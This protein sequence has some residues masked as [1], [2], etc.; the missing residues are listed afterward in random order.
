MTQVRPQQRACLFAYRGELCLPKTPQV[1]WQTAHQGLARSLSPTL[2][3]CGRSF[4]FVTKQKAETLNL[5]EWRFTWLRYE[6]MCVGPFALGIMGCIQRILGTGGTG[7]CTGRLPEHSCRDGRVLSLHIPS[8]ACD[9][10]S[11]FSPSKGCATSCS[12]PGW[13]A[14][15][16]LTVCPEDLLMS[17]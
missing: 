3:C 12:A 7:G 13:G 6:S 17:G 1:R 5:K 9:P 4:V 2:P 8:A 11:S 16:Q 14:S 15:L 10:T